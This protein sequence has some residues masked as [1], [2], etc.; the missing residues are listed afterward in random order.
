MDLYP[1]PISMFCAMEERMQFEREQG[2]EEAAASTRQQQTDE[3]TEAMVPGGAAESAA[4]TTTTAAAAA[5]KRKTVISKGS[6]KNKKCEDVTMFAKN[7]L[8]RSYRP[9][10]MNMPTSARLWNLFA[11]ERYV[12]MDDSDSD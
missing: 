12:D 11:N 3:A 10:P 5:K 9:R 8:D 1:T 4:V 7:K 2:R 6:K